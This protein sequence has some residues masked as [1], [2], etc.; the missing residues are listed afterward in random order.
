MIIATPK[1]A[2]F[3]VFLAGTIDA[4]ASVDWQTE[5]ANQY[6]SCPILFYNPR[7]EKFSEEDDISK[8]I[9][10]ELDHLDFCDV[11]VMNILGDSKSPITLLE[12]GIYS[13]SNKLLVCCPPE[14]YRFDN[15]K[16]VCER[17]NI[18]R[19]DNIEDLHSK[20]RIELYEKGVHL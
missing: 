19:Y 20:F 17:L 1:T 12:L 5:F 16:I 10:W 13:K 14:F 6:S 18:P 11:I 8:Q 15:V 9:N 2:E 4:G 3:S 7:N